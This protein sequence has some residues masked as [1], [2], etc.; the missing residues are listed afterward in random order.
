MTN[1][2]LVVLTMEAASTSETPV[3][4]YEIARRII[5]EEWHL[6]THRRENL[7]SHG[8][9]KNGGISQTPERLQLLRKDSGP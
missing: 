6:Q 2:R 9:H 1:R 7:Q 3:N 8:L 4:F 5:P